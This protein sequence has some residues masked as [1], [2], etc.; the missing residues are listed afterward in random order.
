MSQISGA[1]E[2]FLDRIFNGSEKR[3]YSTEPIDVKKMISHEYIKEN[4]I[5]SETVQNNIIQSTNSASTDVTS[6]LRF[7]DN[8]IDDV[9][10]LSLNTRNKLRERLTCKICLEK[11]DTMFKRIYSLGCGHSICGECNT[12][13]VQRKCPVCIKPI[14]EVKDTP[15][16]YEVDAFIQQFPEK[17][18][19]TYDIYNSTNPFRILRDLNSEKLEPCLDYILENEIEWIDTRYLI[20]GVD[21]SFIGVMATHVKYNDLIK[22]IINK[23]DLHLRT[24][25]LLIDCFENFEIVQFLVNKGVDLNTKD[26]NGLMALDYCWK[27]DR[28]EIAFYLEGEMHRNK[29]SF[30]TFLL[31]GF[32]ALSLYCVLKNPR[33]LRMLFGK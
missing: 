23:Y 27:Y 20:N 28:Q 30:K 7:S 32:G 6:S 16:N 11:Y 13:L 3:E 2:S 21:I 33:F 9:G 25:Q 19:L 10:T 31:Y 8:Y 4:H 22:K 29:N 15:I 17:K 26:K 18:S 12:K 14:L 1:T 5:I 24:D